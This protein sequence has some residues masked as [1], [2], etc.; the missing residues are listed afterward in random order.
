[1]NFQWILLGFF[2]ASLIW[3][4][5]KAMTNPVLKNI[6]NLICIPVAFV[7]TFIMHICGLFQMAVEAVLNYFN[8][9]SYLGGFESAYGLIV[10]SLGLL[11][12]PVFFVLVFQILLILLRFVHTNLIY[13]Y[14][15]HRKERKARIK[16]KAAISS[17]KELVK[18]VI[19][20]TDK[21]T[22]GLIDGLSGVVDAD[23]L[24]D[25]VVN[26]LNL[27]DEDRI[28]EMVDDR[29]RKQKRKAKRKGF[30]KE[31]SEKK[32]ISIVCGA[33]SGF[34]LFAITS[35]PMFYSMDFLSSITDGI[36]TSDAD[37][38]NVYK[39]VSVIDKHFV[40]PYENSFVV[41]FYDNM[42]LVD[43]L[44]DTAKLG[45]KMVLDNGEVLYIDDMF[46]TVLTHGVKIA[47]DIT[48]SKSDHSEIGNDLNA[49]ITDPLLINMVADVLVKVL[50]GVEVPEAEEGDML[51][52]LVPNIIEHY[53]ALDKE[54]LKNDMGA[55]SNVITVALQSGIITDYIGG[56]KEITD[57]VEDKETLG[58]MLSAM[59][60]LSVFSPLMENMFTPAI[61]MMGEMLGVPANNAVAYDTFINK[62]V[63][64]SSGVSPLSAEEI[65]SIKLLV[66]KAAKHDSFYDYVYSTVENL[67]K[68]VDEAQKIVSDIEALSNE[69]E[70]DPT[71]ATDENI[72]KLEQYKSDLQKLEEEAKALQEELSEK[73]AQLTPFITYILSWMNVQ[74]PFMIAGEDTST[75]CLAIEIDGVLYVCNTDEI[76]LEDILGFVSGGGASITVEDDESGIPSIE[77]PE[78]ITK[79]LEKLNSKAV[80][81]NNNSEFDG[82]ISP[83]TD[84]INY[85]IQNS[86]SL[87]SVEALDG[88]LA[89]FKAAH[90]ESES[91]ALTE[92]LYTTSKD[93]FEYKGVTVEMM[94]AA[95]KFGPEV[96]TVDARAA[97][98]KLLV[99]IIFTFMDMMNGSN[100]SDA[101]EG[102]EG[103]QAPAGDSPEALLNMLITLGKVMDTMSKTTCLGE[104]PDLM[105]DAL[106]TNDMLSMV[107]T[108]KMLQD[109][110]AS[111]ENTADFSY[112]AFLS[113]LVQNFSGLLDQMNGEGGTK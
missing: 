30:F 56:D 55:I 73:T 35:M 112:E 89:D 11:L 63:S 38:S 107:M 25:V 59:S 109:L 86:A 104:I 43:V 53:K 65:A 19:S 100:G 36:R 28:E 88:F 83:V 85:I 17:E 70:R 105:L 51:G 45:G 77:L 29:L 14:V 108:P 74:K 52:A 80:T 20:E 7:I 34:L 101:P 62:I 16:L 49:I 91:L 103:T 48:S 60:G 61:G 102:E 15:T 95:L 2:A 1:M 33:V 41:E 97:D 3:Q 18:D 26:S 92:R 31:S 99:E 98:S 71:L 32:A 72:A 13:K 75:A 39:V 40:T 10:A 111:R 110:N 54:G 27:P 46:R 93:S 106:L 81:D 64:A 113:N 94:S 66:K 90:S 44:N 79:L 68:K 9:V 57:I 82:R 47:V 5:A 37:D 76:S 42:A 69:I 50:D 84:F 67:Q 22:Q 6:L 12:T 21:Q 24:H 23:V 87:A 96:W 8:V 78:Y 58:D 4:I